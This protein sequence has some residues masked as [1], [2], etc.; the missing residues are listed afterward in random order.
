MITAVTVLAGV[1]LVRASR[2]RWARPEEGS[3]AADAAAELVH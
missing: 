2:R 3:A 1:L